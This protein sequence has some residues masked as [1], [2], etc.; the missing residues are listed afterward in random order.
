MTQ[1]NRRP[2][3]ERILLTP[4]RLAQLMERSKVRV[5]EARMDVLACLVAA[6]RPLTHHEIAALLP[7]YDASTIF[8]G[9]TEFA[10]S[11]I[12][13]RI[14]TGET[15]RF[16]EIADFRFDGESAPRHPHFYC[17]KCGELRCL[18]DVSLEQSVS[19]LLGISDIKPT[20][21]LVKGLC[22]CC[23]HDAP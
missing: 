8:R 21:L 6:S 3:I 17:V 14:E 9:L 4:A 10:A 16:F 18:R 23:R 13:W 22:L 12:V 2:I 1:Q 15:D 19:I 5:T 20:D 7:Q 11:N